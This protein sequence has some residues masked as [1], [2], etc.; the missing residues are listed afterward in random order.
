M[1]AFRIGAAALAASLLGAAA[2]PAEPVAVRF[3]EGPS[4][5]FVVL[6]DTDDKALAHGELVQWLEDEVVVSHLAFRFADGSIYDETVRFSQDRVF[7]LLSYDLEQR[8]PSFTEASD[9]AFDRSGRYDVRLRSAPDEE[10]QRASGTVDVPEDVMNGMT[11]IF[12][13]NRMP[14]GSGAARLLA[15]TPDPVVLDVAFVAQGS[16]RYWI[17]RTARTATRYLIDPAVPGVKGVL[18]TL[19]G[20][21]PPSFRMWIAQ[22]K[23]PILIRFEGPLYAEGPTWRIGMTAPRLDR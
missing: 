5:G 15:F 1:C 11:S 14:N 12:L 22:G 16:D 20:K 2:A 17:G 3:R 13:K 19:V 18:A 23:A 9:I 4:H 6:S 21:Q 7:R 8:G 10:E